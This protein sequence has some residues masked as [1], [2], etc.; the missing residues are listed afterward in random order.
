[1]MLLQTCCSYPARPSI[2]PVRPEGEKPS[3]A[4]A[5]TASELRDWEDGDVVYNPAECPG[6]R[7]RTVP[8]L[9]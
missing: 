6:V 7:H 3:T 5:L 4:D 9:P 2:D 8:N 1:M